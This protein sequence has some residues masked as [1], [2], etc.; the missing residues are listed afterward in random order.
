M[1]A[2]TID[3]DQEQI[4]R[5]QKLAD[6]LTEIYGTKVSRASVIRRAIMAFEPS[7]IALYTNEEEVQTD[8]S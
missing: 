8:V 1:P 4:D 7:E 2:I 5:A 3:L 6:R